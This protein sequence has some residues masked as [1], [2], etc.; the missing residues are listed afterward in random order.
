MLHSKMTWLKV[1]LRKDA[2]FGTGLRAQSNTRPPPEDES[3]GS[4]DG[5]L[6]TVL[7]LLDSFRHSPSPTEV[8]TA[9]W[10][11]TRQLIDLQLYKD[12]LEFHSI[13]LRRLEA[14]AH[15]SPAQVAYDMPLALATQALLLRLSER[16]G[17]AREAIRRA[18]PFAEGLSGDNGKAMTAI[19]FKVMAWVDDYS[20]EAAAYLE[21]AIA[22]YWHLIARYPS[23]YLVKYLESLSLLGKVML[24]AGDTLKAIAVLEHAVLFGQHLDRPH[25]QP[26]KEHILT[27]LDSALQ[28]AGK[29]PTARAAVSHS[30][31]VGNSGDGLCGAHWCTRRLLMHRRKN[32]SI[33]STSDSHSRLCN[34][35]SSALDIIRSVRPASTRLTYRAT[36]DYGDA[37]YM[38]HNKV[39]IHCIGKSEYQYYH[40]RFLLIILMKKG[41]S[42]HLLIKPSLPK[43]SMTAMELVNRIRNVW[44]SW[45]PSGERWTAY[46]KKDLATEMTQFTERRRRSCIWK[47]LRLRFHGK[48]SEAHKFF[49]RRL[50]P[51][52]LHYIPQ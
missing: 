36:G 1:L 52:S 42:M 43:T 46:S 30:K 3:A 5:A 24:N 47:R 33:D 34:G 10:R 4:M 45:I 35:I 7:L 27:R 44:C 50:S 20:L 11:L 18:I 32:T 14:L 37:Q 40:V 19:C 41:S 39:L 9:L 21:Q 22:I 17:D 15:R 28:S 6:A 48:R 8:M 16:D 25:H 2:V 31:D 51:T 23:R 49:L 29:G 38:Q 26:I 12:A 13:A